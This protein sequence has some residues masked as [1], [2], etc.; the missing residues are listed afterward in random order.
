MLFSTLYRIS[1]FLFC[2]LFAVP[3]SYWQNRTVWTGVNFINVFKCSFHVSSSQ[4]RKKLLELTVFFAL[5]WSA[6]LK[7]APKM[8]VKLTA[9]MGRR[10][11]RCTECV[12]DLDELN[13]VN[14]VIELGFGL[15]QNFLRPQL[16]LKW[17]RIQK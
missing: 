14:L 7:V 15:N 6:Y 4:K 2:C 8:L 13:L 10:E 9:G 17:C 5:L 3:S 11:E 1:G 16:P 12:R